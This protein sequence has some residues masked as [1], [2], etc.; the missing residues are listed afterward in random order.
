MTEETKDL[1]E[2][3]EFAAAV[4]GLAGVADA[5]EAVETMEAAEDVEFLIP[6]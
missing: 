6:N 3:M 4:T 2:D 5:A 1:A